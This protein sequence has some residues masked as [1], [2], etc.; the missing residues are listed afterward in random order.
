MKF[1]KWSHNDYKNKTIFNTAQ[2][3]GCNMFEYDICSTLNGRIYVAHNWQFPWERNYQGIT[4]IIRK[5]HGMNFIY[6]EFKTGNK[7]ALQTI[8][9]FLHLLSIDARIIIGG[10]DYN[11]FSKLFQH[12]RKLRDSIMDVVTAKTPFNSYYLKSVITIE[13]FEEQYRD[14]YEKVRLYESG[15][16]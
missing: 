5:S 2:K 8:L 3:A 6:I 4:E 15:R 14:K 12:R 16:D 11:I 13:Q 10:D 7:R 9:E 1:I